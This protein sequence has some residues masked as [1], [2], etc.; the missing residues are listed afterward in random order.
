MLAGA[1]QHIAEATVP[2]NRQRP[3]LD[4]RRAVAPILVIARIVWHDREEWWPARAV[5]W[6][7]TVVHVTWRDSDRARSEWIPASDVRRVIVTR[8]APDR[9]DAAGT[10][11]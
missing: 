5:A 4:A 2:A 7:D 11:P 3:P 10:P 6:S 1:G 8:P 9:P